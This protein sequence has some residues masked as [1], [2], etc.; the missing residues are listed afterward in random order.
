MRI[1]ELI[2]QNDTA[3]KQRWLDY[4]IGTYPADSR[5]FF[6]NQ[7]NQFSNPVGAALAKQIDSLFPYILTDASGSQT[8]AVLEDFIKI[9]AVQEFTPSQAIGFILFLKQAII[10]VLG[11]EIEESGLYQEL[12]EIDARIDKILLYAFEIYTKSR[13]QLFEIRTGELKRGMF[14]A[15][16]LKARDEKSNDD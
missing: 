16:K 7:K 15:L 9:R 2:R 8:P 10:E 12:W 14:M 1:E 4:I 5:N 13:D 3:I 6:S 11:Q